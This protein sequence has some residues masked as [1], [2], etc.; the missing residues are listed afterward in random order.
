VNAYLKNILPNNFPT[1]TTD[2]TQYFGVTDR[3][4]RAACFA[5]NRLNSS[6]AIILD[7]S[8]FLLTQRRQRNPST[9][10]TFIFTFGRGLRDYLLLIRE[11]PHRGKN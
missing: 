6:K 7:Y 3:S 11:V 9:K 8:R 10:K 2:F 4:W 5:D 1:S